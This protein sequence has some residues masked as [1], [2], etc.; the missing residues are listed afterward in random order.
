MNSEA[1]QTRRE[2]SHQRILDA[3]A[4]AVRRHGYAGVGVAEVMKE[5]GLTH[6][7]FYAHFKSRDALLAA[8]LDHAGAGSARVLARRL[9]LAREAGISPLRA[10]VDGYLSEEHV[11]A[12]ERG[13]PVAAL[14]SEMSRQQEDVLAASRRRVLGLI[15]IVRQA[16]PPSASEAQAQVI[17]STLVGTLQ[18]ARALGDGAGPLLQASREA[19]LAQYDKASP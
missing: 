17:A 7:G 12:A 13:C 6:G 19:L 9:E 1:K 8:A 3:A 2:L 4:R 16:L 15:G 18:L 14:G 5:A 11:A 10:L